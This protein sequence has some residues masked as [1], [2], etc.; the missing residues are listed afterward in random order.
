MGE[1]G[2]KYDGFHRKRLPEQLAE[3]TQRLQTEFGQDLDLL[4]NSVLGIFA[5]IHAERFAAIWEELEDV[6]SAMYPMSATGSN[7]DR[8]VAFTGVT[9]LQAMPSSVDV[10]FYGKLGT[11]IPENTA[12]RNH[13]TQTEYFTLNKTVISAEKAYDVMLSL[14]DNHISAGTMIALTLDGIQYRYTTDR[15]SMRYALDEL[16]KQLKQVPYLRIQTAKDHIRITGD[17]VT[18][19]SIGAFNGVEFLNVGVLQECIT[20]G[21]ST[22]LAEVNS[23]TE[24]VATVSGV[25]RIT[26]LHQ[27][28]KGREIETDSELYRR[29]HLGTYRTGAA[30]V[31]SLLANLREVE[32]VTDCLV[33][34]NTSNETNQHGVPAHS[35]HCVV[36]GGLDKSIAQTIFNLKPAGIPTYGTTTVNVLDSQGFNHSI[37]F[38]RPTRKYIWVNATVTTFVDQREKARSGYQYEI[39]M[40]IKNYLESLSVGQDV[41]L[42]RLVGKCINVEGVGEIAITLGV[43]EQITDSE[44]QYHAQNIVLAPHEEAIFDEGLVRIQ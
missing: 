20:E 33:Y 6:Y 30:T 40:A 38:S 13:L 4:P 27:G 28:T 9:R 7:L 11:E 5:H 12:V 41:I 31:N 32:G 17:T 16:A 43:T 18:T 42:Q 26:N 39:L 10:V 1:Y 24:L 23:V 21:S 29:Y 3:V 19:F 34:E 44:P 22:D 14:T 15:S 2:L 35:V 36:K 8:A 25:E 37:N